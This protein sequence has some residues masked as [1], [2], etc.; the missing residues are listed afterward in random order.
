[1]LKSHSN[2]V[3]TALRCAMAAGLATG[4]MTAQATLI[5]S[6]LPAVLPGN[7]PSLGYQATS[8]SEFG[9]HV[10]FAAGPR[11][12]D[13]ATVTMSNWALASTYASNTAGY[14]HDLTLNIYQYS[15]TAVA[16]PLLASVTQNTFV[17][18]RPEADPT[19]PGGTAWRDASGTCY[20]GLAFNVQF[21]FAALGLDL[22]D[23]IVFGLAY[24]TQSY[25]VNPI[26]ADGPYNSLNFG[27]VSG[28]PS[29]GTDVDSDAV[30]WNTSYQP[31]LT[32]GI[33]GV[34]G[35]DTAWSGYV[36]AIS[37]DAIAVPEPAS[38]A[39]AGFALAGLWASR[40]RRVG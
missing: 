10:Q 6:D 33:A 28:P 3:G 36:P 15:G 16:G 8:T 27:L 21:D 24:N 5:Y 2:V 19:C 37:F 17:P 22:P 35:T 26:G 11:R 20:N 9:D 7:L 30:F 31:F 29:V 32:T 12:L 34:F 13:T 38:L 14:Y 1:M 23:D 18:W 40:R 25:G 4:A 39:L